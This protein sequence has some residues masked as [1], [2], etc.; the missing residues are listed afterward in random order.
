M[1]S[2]LKVSLL[3]V[4]CTATFADV[5]PDP[6]YSYIP[7]DLILE[8]T[9]DLSAFRFFLLSP[10]DLE[11]VRIAAGSPT[12]ISARNRGGVSLYGRLFAVPISE[13]GTDQPNEEDPDGFRNRYESA[14]EVL[15]HSF[16]E[17]VSVIQ[18]PFWKGPIYKLSADGGRVWAT[19]I[20]VDSSRSL[21][22]YAVP[23]VIGGVLIAMGIAIIGI[24]LFRRSRK[25]V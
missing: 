19:K 5:A 22:I 21:L 1:R 7:V 23:M 2:L 6:G 16:K 18:K 13:I 3:L 25:K 9:Q 10:A 8:P 20:Q 14:H 4:L 24:W 17:E 11:E 15:S 12:V